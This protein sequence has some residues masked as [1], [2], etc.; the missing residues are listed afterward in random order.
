MAKMAKI[1]NITQEAICG[2]MKR[3]YLSKITHN[4]IYII[5]LFAKFSENRYTWV[6]RVLNNEY[7]CAYG[8]FTQFAFVTISA[9]HKICAICA[10]YAICAIHE[11]PWS[12]N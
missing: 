10:T 5:T 11:Y 4:I 2:Y 7:N 8:H 9:T 1:M 3:S 6:I 12:F